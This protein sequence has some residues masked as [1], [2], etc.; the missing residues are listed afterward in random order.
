M[1]LIPCFAFS[2]SEETKDVL[3]TYREMKLYEV[4]S[5]RVVVSVD[6]ETG[7]VPKRK[8]YKI[9]KDYFVDTY[10]DHNSELTIDNWVE[11]VLEVRSVYFA[12]SSYIAEPD[13]PVNFHAFYTMRVTIENDKL[14]V[15]CSAKDWGGEWSTIGF[16]YR[17]E[18][19]SIVDCIP[20]GD[21][22]FFDDGDKTAKTF[23]DLIDRM[24][25]S[26][27][28]LDGVLVEKI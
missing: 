8:L 9:V 4:D 2:Q 18:Q 21:K 1:L 16:G 25:L 11:G 5:N 13:I 14:Q 28:E 15:R 12:F 17:M 6:L 10:S 7:K 20:L 27:K 22:K 26:V 23:L 3:T 19:F 24:Y